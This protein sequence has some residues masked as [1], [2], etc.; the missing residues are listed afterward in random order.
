MNAQMFKIE[1]GYVHYTVIA[2]ISIFPM[3]RQLAKNKYLL[4]VVL[5][6]TTQPPLSS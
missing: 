6:V 5:D 1:R 4:A 2:V 3:V